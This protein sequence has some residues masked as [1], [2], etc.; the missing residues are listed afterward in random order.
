MGKLV[1]PKDR[2][3][4]SPADLARGLLDCVTNNVVGPT[5]SAVVGEDASKPSI[6]H[7]TCPSPS[8]PQGSL[9]MMHAKQQNVEH[10]VFAG[11]FLRSNDISCTP[12]VC[13][14]ASSR[15]RLTVRA[16]SSGPPHGGL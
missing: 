10:V 5:P 3:A 16:V 13:L 9:A 2:E 12:A 1:R 11:N 6:P 15:Q 7:A 4:A 14:P 8:P